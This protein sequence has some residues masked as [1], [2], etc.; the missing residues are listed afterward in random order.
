MRDASY[1]SLPYNPSLES[2]SLA[3]ARMML[4]DSK[5]PTFP[6]GLKAA[7]TCPK[8]MCLKKTGGLA[9]FALEASVAAY[10]ACLGFVVRRER[11]RIEV[12]QPRRKLFERSAAQIEIDAS[13]SG[14]DGCFPDSRI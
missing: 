14:H 10:F 12:P 2:P 11:T 3:T 6:S 8:R 13:Q 7:G 5:I 1:G 9:Q 4:F